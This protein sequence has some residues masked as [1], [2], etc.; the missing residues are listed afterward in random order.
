MKQSGK[1]AIQSFADWLALTKE[2]EEKF[3]IH[4]T[5]QSF[6]IQRTKEIENNIKNI[7]NKN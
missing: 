4:K 7:L 6:H 2:R 3:I 5:K 1:T